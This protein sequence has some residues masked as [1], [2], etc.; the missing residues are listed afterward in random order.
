M[1]RRQFIKYG[2]GS[3]LA[4]QL[5][6]YGCTRIYE[7]DYASPIVSVFDRMATSLEYTAGSIVNSDGIINDRI[8]S[9]DII[10]DRVARMVDTAIMKLTGQPSVGKAWE[11]L[12]PAG[13]PNKDTTV[14]IKI[15]FS[16]GDWRNDRE[17]D[18]SKIYCPF[19]PKAA[20]TNA[21]VSGLTQMLD[22][23]FP[24]GNIT[25]VER[26]RMRGYHKKFPLVQGYREIFPDDNGIW[27]DKRA[28]TYGIHWINTRNDLELPSDGP[29]FIAAPDYPREYQA[30]Q[31]IFAGIYQHDFLINYA[32]GKDHRAAGITGAMKNN[33]GC[34]DNPMGT[35]GM[36]WTNDNS[37]YAGT[38]LCVP[39]FYKNVDKHAPYILNIMDALTGI[40]HGGPLFGKVFHANTIAMSKDPVA[41]D[42]Y[43]LNLINKVR[44]DKGLSVMTTEDGWTPDGHKQAPFLRI[45]VEDHG[46]G[47]PSMEDLQQIDLSG[48]PAQ[49]HVPALQQSQSRISEV[50]KTGS[51]YRMQVLLD[52]SGRKHTI[53]S[54]IEDL[55]GKVVRH[56]APRSTML[57]NAVLEWDHRN[58]A[59]RTVTEGIY[60]W[61]VTVDGI[62]H[63]NT[64]NDKNH[65]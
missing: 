7:A 5:L 61:Y 43:L 1:E 56:L 58:H 36:D 64:I 4:A 32:I 12:F 47:S 50:R 21:I 45:A 16:Y 39:V 25:L 3:M 41:I 49:S 57:S 40:Y 63:T 37:P 10:N 28:G 51:I 35:H 19:G 38:R 29:K 60:V 8:L 52:H 48:G 55:E 6:P 27:Q 53:E 20:V 17:N 2:M 54:R 31:R 26:I 44:K 46:L 15:N 42:T 62:T 13:H 22:G 34:A 11:S 18:W 9:F 14:G 23:T 33:Y 59:Q 65:V 30:P 24:I